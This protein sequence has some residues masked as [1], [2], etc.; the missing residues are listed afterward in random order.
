MTT[1]KTIVALFFICPTVF[2]NYAYA[3]EGGAALGMKNALSDVCLGNPELQAARADAESSGFFAD[4]ARYLYLPRVELNSYVGSSGNKIISTEVTQTLWDGGRI[5]SNVSSMGE[6]RNADIFKAQSKVDD[7]SLRII[8]TYVNLLRVAEQETISQKNVTKHEMFYGSSM[9]RRESG[10]G[11]ASDVE[12]VLSRLQQARANLLYWKGEREK[13][14]TSYMS[15][16]G[17]APPETISILS[18]SENHS[19]MDRNELINKAISR[20]P[21]LEAL[22]HELSVAQADVNHSLAQNFP[23]VFA[24][25]NH[26]AGGD[27]SSLD[28]TGTSMT[29][30]L[31][32]QNDVGFSQRFQTKAAR[33]K[34]RSAQYMLQSAEN[35][36]RELVSG[37]YTGYTTAESKKA[38]L[39]KFKQSATKTV[40]MY[41]K[42]FIIGRRTWPDLVNSLQDLYNAESQLKDAEYQSVLFFLKSQVLTGNMGAAAGCKAD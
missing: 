37:L 33:M 32:W 26:N 19:V 17:H 41:E 38:E 22:R 13:Y 20:S 31:Q 14:A 9:K 2:P 1:F 3:F 27:K 40:E 18:E 35:N 24:K 16:V 25:A 10:L 15:L 11:N 36:L 4:Y 28:Q 6:K 29:L 12:M 23:V 42:Q 8:D 39:I 34:V 30:N 7:L 21:V 5:S